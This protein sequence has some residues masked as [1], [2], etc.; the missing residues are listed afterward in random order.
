MATVVFGCAD[1]LAFF[2]LDVPSVSVDISDGVWNTCLLACKLLFAFMILARMLHLHHRFFNRV[3]IKQ[4]PPPYHTVADDKQQA[5]DTQQAK[6]MQQADE[7]A[8]GGQHAASRP[9]EAQQADEHQQADDKTQQ[10]DEHASR[11]EDKQQADDKNDDTTPAAGSGLRA[12]ASDVA[13]PALAFAICIS[14]KLASGL[15]VFLG[16]AVAILLPCDC[17]HHHPSSV[18]ESTLESVHSQARWRNGSSSWR[19]LQNRI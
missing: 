17:I 10:A 15:D 3:D 12:V 5:D 2:T 18:S 19:I 14:A 1:V 8:A 16:L 13:M 6:N 7:H 4:Q 11:Q 9:H